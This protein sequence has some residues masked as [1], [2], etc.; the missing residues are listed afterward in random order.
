MTEILISSSALILALLVMRRL[1]RNSISRRVQ[2][3]LWALVLVRLLVPMHLPAMDF[4]VL[5]ATMPMEETVTENIMMQEIEGVS[6]TYHDINGGYIER[7]GDKEFLSGT[8]TDEKIR[9][10]VS[11][12]YRQ[13]QRLLDES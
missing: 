10:T 3:A 4:S 5:T 13:M 1:F 6:Y 11:K 9:E 8:V 12:H 2:Y 7:T